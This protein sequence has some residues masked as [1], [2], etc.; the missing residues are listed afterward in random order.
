MTASKEREGSPLAWSMVDGARVYIDKAIEA[1]CQ[2]DAGNRVIG[3]CVEYL[4]QLAV[5]LDAPSK[6]K[7]LLCLSGDNCDT[8]CA[9]KSS[10]PLR[11]RYGPLAGFQL[12]F[13]LPLLSFLNRPDLNPTQL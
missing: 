1:L 12:F 10:M 3:R 11:N 13:V 9:A 6:S 8:T 2:L 7:P 5:I 4:S